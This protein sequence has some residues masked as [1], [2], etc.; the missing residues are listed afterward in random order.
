LK[1]FLKQNWEKL[2]ATALAVAAVLYMASKQEPEAP[3]KK[4]Q[5]PNF[6]SK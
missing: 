5:R 6:G 1:E 4:R 3:A 2:A